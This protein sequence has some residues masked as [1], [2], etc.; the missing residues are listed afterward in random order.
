[1]APKN[2]LTAKLIG[3]WRSVAVMDPP[4]SGY[5]RVTPDLKFFAVAPMPP[6]SKGIIHYGDFRMLAEHFT[7]STFDIKSHDLSKASCLFPLA[8]LTAVHRVNG[9]KRRG[10]HG[11]NLHVGIDAVAAALEERGF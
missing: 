4:A 7:T 10:R 5:F 1:M 9:E 8:G 3:N 11:V 2:P 6:N